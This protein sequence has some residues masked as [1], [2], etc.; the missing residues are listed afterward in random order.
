MKSRKLSPLP[1]LDE[2]ILL[3]A[4]TA[5]DIKPKHAKILWRNVI[6]LGITD[7]DQI[8]DFPKR[9]KELFSTG[10]F[11][12]CTSKVIS[13]TDSSDGSTTKLLIELQDGRQIESVIMRYGD[14]ELRSFPEQER[15]KSLGATQTLPSLSPTSVNE[16]AQSLNSHGSRPFR[17]TRRATVCVS[18][19]VGCAM[20][21][22]FCATGTMG[23]LENLSAGEILEQVYHANQIERIRGVVF[24]G[25]G[26][27]LDNYNNV[28]LA[29]NALVDTAR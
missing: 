25:M 26:E 19:Q 6:Q 5:H 22:K 12:I 29:V 24:M 21:C 11:T 8:N 28:R 20:G 15:I 9:A 16:D 14:V 3:E 7:L 18:S 27:P 17:S 4:F 13:R 23:L 1:A 10:Q 2:H